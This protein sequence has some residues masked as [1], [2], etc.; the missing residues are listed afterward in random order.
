M[1]TKSKLFGYDIFSGSINELVN[2]IISNRINVVHCINAHAF[3]VA[4][5]NEKFKSA[6]MRSDIIIADGV[7]LTLL[8]KFYGKKLTRITGWDI[9]TAL[10]QK[11]N[12]SHKNRVFFLG[13]STQTLQ[14]ITD[15]Y[16]LDYPNVTVNSYSPPYKESFSTEENEEIIERISNFAPDIVYVGMTAP[17]QELWV[18]ANSHK[19]EETA[20]ISIGAVFDFYAGTIK[21]APSIIQKVGF[22]WLF[23]SLISPKRLG[24]RNLIS[25]PEFIMRVLHRMITGEK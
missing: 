14:L 20:F 22:E 16:R 8:G 13:S 23:R 6:L 9:F 15:R 21:R 19:F 10:N 12:H 17:K 1:S 3:N 18:N 25:N 4:E 11:L 24:K 5:R 2:E 7:S